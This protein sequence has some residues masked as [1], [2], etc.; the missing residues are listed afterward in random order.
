M[1]Q[2]ARARQLDAEIDYHLDYQFQQWRGIPEVAEWWPTMEA[3]EREDFHLEWVGITEAR[4]QQLKDW[5]QQGAMRPNQRA[6]FADLIALVECHRPT[7][8]RLLDE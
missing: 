8:Q 6:R 4:L 3:H 7:L 5:A 1:A 2:V